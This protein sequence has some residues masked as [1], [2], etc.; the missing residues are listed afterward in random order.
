MDEFPYA[1]FPR[2]WYRVAW[3]WDVTETIEPVSY[4]GRKLIRF[5]TSDGTAHVWDAVCPHLGA[6]LGYGGRLEGDIVVCPFHGWGWDMEGCNAFIPYEDGPPRRTRIRRFETRERCGMVLAWWAGDGR[7][8]EW[9]PDEVPESLDRTRF[10]PLSADTTRVWPSKHLIPQA[11]VEN[12]AD[13]AHVKYVHLSKSVPAVDVTITG[14]KF[15]SEQ[16]YLFG[17]G[18]ERTWLTPEGPRRIKL[19]AE[20]HGLGV[21]ISRYGGLHTAVHLLGATPLDEHNSE[22]WAAAVVPRQDDD[23]GEHALGRWGT[24]LVSEMFKS[25]DQDFP[26][27]ENMT[28]IAHPPYARVEAACHRP[29]RQW[30]SSFYG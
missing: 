11:I 15:V 3:S 12:L 8:P 25:H 23:A 27:W 1:G 16:E 10:H 2:G 24:R 6:H 20:A 19:V 30:A 21:T 4:F 7:I 17:E 28:Y 5:R 14:H 29:L 22:V 13:P 18:R 9:E 26:I